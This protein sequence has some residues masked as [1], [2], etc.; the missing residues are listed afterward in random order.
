MGQL[1]LTKVVPTALQMLLGIIVPLFLPDL[2]KAYANGQIDKMKTNLDF[3]FKA[4]F[5]IVLLPIAIFFVYG[6][7]FFKLWLPKEDSK[8]LYFLS[9]VTLIPFLIHGIIE[10]I[11]HVF[12]ITNKLKAASLWGIFI[13]VTSFI[14]V[15]LLC[16]YSNLGIYAI[17]MAT[18]IT[19]T[20]SH[21]TFTP[22]YAAKCLNENVVYF[23]KRILKGAF[24]FIVLVT[25]AFIWKEAKLLRSNTWFGL[26]SNL[27]IVGVVLFIVCLFLMFDRA[28]LQ[29]FYLE[30]RK[31]IKI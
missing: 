13:S 4:I 26:F 10:T 8:Q 3:S 22:L 7:D 29:R 16:R 24:S 27:F 19:G 25:V 17:P 30:I 20:I 12:V 2:L 28:I 1:S 11:H 21:L 23:Y 5:L 18:L 6:E 14:L 15:I 31:K 9:I